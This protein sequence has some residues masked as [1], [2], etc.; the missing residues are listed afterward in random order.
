MSRRVR[1]S[2]DCDKDVHKTIET[3]RNQAL[4]DEDLI[5]FKMNTVS[6]QQWYRFIMSMGLVKISKDFEKWKKQLETDDDK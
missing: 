2:I 5:F 6:M 4:T 1:I 3:L